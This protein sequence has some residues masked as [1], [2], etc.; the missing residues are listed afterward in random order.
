MKR[1]MIFLLGCMVLLSMCTPSEQKQTITIQGKVEFPDNQ[2]NIE[3]I[4]RDQF[5]KVVV[6]SCKV[7]EDGTYSIQLLVEE[8][9]MYTLDCQKWQ[10]VNF[11]AEDE[12]LVIDFRGMDT[13]KVKIKNPPYV[14]IYGGPNNELMNLVNWDDYRY[15]QQM[16]A[17]SQNLHKI[18]I[19]PLKRQETFT[20]LF[21]ALN[22]DRMA[23]SRFLAKH[24]AD[25][26]SVLTIL[27]GLRSSD[28]QPLVEEVLGKLEAKNPN[29][30]P[31]VAFKTEREEKKLQTE[32]V[33]LGQPAPEFAYPTTDKQKTMGPQDFKGNYLVIDFWASWCGPCRK[34][35]P[36]MKKA[37][38]QFS[39]KGVSFF[40]VSI[41]SKEADWLKALDEEKM[42]WDQVL[43]PEAGKE[44]MKL[45]QFSGIP[46]IVLLDKE[47]NILA[48]NLRGEQLIEKLK[49]VTSK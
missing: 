6:D 10:A 2:F 44:V 25:R 32:R 15:Y 13:A 36:N 11:W 49:E 20:S 23:R 39:G 7:N 18:D 27:P 24:Y 48:K 42:P 35:M 33:A 41:D 9:G 37:Y 26:N 19:D 12:D 40:N 29:Y 3:V 28:D 38:E 21:G 16:I 30:A 43:A 34:E 46:F 4:K 17:I 47:G 45:Y 5:D 8:P 31:L 14:H 22:E 1:Q